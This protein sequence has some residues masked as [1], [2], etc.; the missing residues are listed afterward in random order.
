MEKKAFQYEMFLCRGNSEQAS[1]SKPVAPKTSSWTPLEVNSWRNKT[2]ETLF[3]CKGWTGWVLGTILASNCGSMFDE[4]YTTA[5]W[6]S[7]NNDSST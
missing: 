5:D 4:D 1:R 6:S 7:H 2:S 3:F